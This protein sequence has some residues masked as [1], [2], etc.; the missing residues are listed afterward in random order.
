MKKKYNIIALII[1]IITFT[2][3]TEKISYSGKILD[4]NN[5]IHSYSTK[6]EIINNLGEPSYIDPIESKY[7]Y[8]TEKR[9][10]KNYFNNKI[11]ENKLIVFSFNQNDTIQSVNEYNVDK[12][13]KIK[14][15]NDKTPNTIIKQ[16]I[17]EKVFGGVKAGPST[18][19]NQ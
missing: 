2:S 4:L 18:V 10:S 3:C 7:F 12:D 14:I 9:S 13:K 8:Y 16:G 15:I 19:A 5:D 17:L 1:I 6:K 11:I